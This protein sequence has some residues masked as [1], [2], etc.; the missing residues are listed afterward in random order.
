M[1]WL[2]RGLLLAC[3][4]AVGACSMQ[5]TIDGMSAPEDRAYALRFV[6]SLRSGKGDGL[7]NEFDPRIWE[8]SR[9]RFAVA[10]AA[11]PKGKVE[12][13]LIGYRVESNFTAGTTEKEFVL[14]TTDGQRWT[15]TTVGT[16]AQGGP[17]KIVAW[18]VEPFAEPPPELRMIETMDRILPWLQ[19]GLLILLLAGIGLLGWLVVRSIRRKAERREGI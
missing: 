4:L 7:K 3:L 1:A 16:F 8:K 5:S 11:F 19:G 18:N 10:Q 9:A 12:T 6:D 2:V 15:R 17:A 13:R 14:S